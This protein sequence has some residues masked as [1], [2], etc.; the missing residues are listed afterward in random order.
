MLLRRGEAAQ[1]G[2]LLSGSFTVANFRFE[3]EGPDDPDALW[4]EQERFVDRRPINV[5]TSRVILTRAI[6]SL[7][8]QDHRWCLMGRDAWAVAGPG[9]AGCG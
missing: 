3:Y 2:P 6:W 5:G 7:R 1:G 4:E 9:M 8:G